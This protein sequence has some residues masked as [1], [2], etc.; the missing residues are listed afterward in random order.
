MYLD[1]ISLGISLIILYG[2]YQKWSW[3]LWTMM[4]RLISDFYIYFTPGV[5]GGMTLSE[6][7][8]L[9]ENSSVV[10]LP[11]WIRVLPAILFI[12]KICL[13]YLLI[14]KIVKSDWPPKR[15]EK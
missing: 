10:V 5:I 13:L 15:I 9:L 1:I 3:A 8:P 12:F 7:F 2:L 4:I 14:A 6:I 11:I